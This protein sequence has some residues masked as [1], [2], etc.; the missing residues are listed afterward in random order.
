MAD[1]FVCVGKIIKPQGIKG[2]VKIM[3][4]VDIPAIFNGKHALYVEKEPMEIISGTF[5]LGY[6]Y[7]KFAKIIDRNTAEKYR[8]KKV[9]ITKEEFEKL[10]DDHFLID[11]LIGTIIYDEKGDLVGQIMDVVDYGF[12][13]ILIIKEDGITYEV[14]F[15]KA[16]FQS[17]G[18]NLT[19]IRSEYEGSKVVQE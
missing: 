10:S 15:R 6:A 8:N 18:K 2:E 9:Y 1:N 19:A 14:P 4:S 11:D 16:I 3:P 13:D 12:D 5:R 7:I 17:N